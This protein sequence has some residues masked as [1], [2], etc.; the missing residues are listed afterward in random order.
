METHSSA[1]RD[2]ENHEN[3]LFEQIAIAV[4]NALIHK[5]TCMRRQVFVSAIIAVLAFASGCTSLS[6]SRTR[7]DSAGY[8]QCQRLAGQMQQDECMMAEAIK[9]GDT[10]EIKALLTQESAFVDVNEIHGLAQNQTWLYYTL[11][12]M[13][14]Q[15]P[16]QWIAFKRS[17]NTLFD[18][19][20]YPDLGQ[21]TSYG[22][23]SGSHILQPVLRHRLTNVDPPGVAEMV[24]MLIGKSQNPDFM[25]DEGAKI[26]LIS[27]IARQ[28]TF[29]STS[30]FVKQLID[31]GANVNLA[32]SPS[33]FTALMEVSYRGGPGLDAKPCSTM[34]TLLLSA[35]ADST[36][37]GWNGFRAIDFAQI[38]TACLDTFCHSRACT[39]DR[40]RIETPW[41][42]AKLKEHDLIVRVLSDAGSP[43]SQIPPKDPFECPPGVG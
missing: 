8:R 37:R 25:I 33:G 28:C 38:Y 18:N 11:A 10:I 7:L 17:I 1:V 19:G 42:L 26:P 35:G 29:S 3:M 15:S 27:Y 16:Q 14:P 20:A 39:K 30:G 5:A 31:K 32:S 23:V 13:W 2:T 34:T 36:V 6:N 22:Q 4:V 24:T 21:W 41:D 40:R 43:P 9:I 12:N